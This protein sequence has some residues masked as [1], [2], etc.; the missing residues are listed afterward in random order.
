[1]KMKNALIVNGGHNS[2]KRDQLGNYDLI[3]AVD[4][5]TEQAYKLFLKPDLIIGD[6]DS[7]DEKTIKRAEKDEVQILKYDTNKN[8]T[9]FELALKHVINKEI[10]DITIIGGEYGE[11]DHLF[12]V[13]TVII[14]F[15]ED[16]KIS[17]IH[18]DQTVLIP[19]SKKITIGSNVEFSIL[20][21]TNLKN[22]NISGAQWNLDNEN[23]E[24]GKSVTLRNISIDNDIE[25][26]VEDGK[27]CLIYNN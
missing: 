22:L 1:M 27:F 21:F 3:V 15:Q 2:T 11:I 9:D 12:G 19:N 4:S 10:K 17:W 7:I 20:P 26:S 18:K 8:Q 5:G 16:Q 6:L 13:L 14:S 25:V 23:I 24:F